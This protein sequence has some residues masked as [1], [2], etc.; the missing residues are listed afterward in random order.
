MN[1]NSKSSIIKQILSETNDYR[2]L[3]TMIVPNMLFDQWSLINT[4]YFYYNSRFQ[5]GATDDE[6]D[7]KYF[8]NIVKNPCMIY[9]KS[10]AFKPESAKLLTTGGGD[11][12]KTWFMERDLKYWMRDKQF[13]KVMNR[14]FH[15]LPIFG[16]VVIKMVQGVPYFVDLRN[17]LIDKSADSL[18][19]MQFIVEQH[20]MTKGE[21]R[22]KAKILGVPQ[23]KI[24]EVI[25]KYEEGKY[26]HI[27]VYERYGDVEVA[28]KVWK[29]QRTFIAD[30]GVDKFLNNNTGAV[31]ISER[32]VELKSEDY[33]GHPYWEFHGQKI[34]GR[35]LGVGVIETLM[36]PQIA[37]NELMNLQSKAAYWAALR[38]FQTR[39]SAV[40]RNLNTDVSNGQIMNVD[41]EI[42]QIDMSDRNL[43][44]FNEMTQKWNANIN[45]LTV[46]FVPIGHSQAAIQVALDRVVTYFEHIQQQVALQ[47]KEMIYSDLMPQ[48]E[49][50]MTAEHV[51]RLVGKDLDTFVQMVKNTM[52]FQE[53][54]RLAVTQGKI[55]TQQDA[56]L[57]G[58]AIEL[59]IKGKKEHLLTVTKGFYK[60]VKYD[61]EIDIAGE[62]ID[63]KGRQQMKMAVLQALT[64][65][66]T[67]TQD[68]AK[69][70]ILSSYMEDGGMNP[71]DIFSVSGNT[72][73][74]PTQSNGGG[75]SGAGGGVSSMN[76]MG[77]APAKTI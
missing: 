5:S 31:Q 27:T 48:F 67:L 50:D 16:S 57:I 63:T 36:E 28:P 13:G 55:C 25:A 24:D 22:K 23:A 76:G 10:I 19:E 60:G 3:P 14:I 56:D 39:D 26:N 77:V 69:K 74:A 29:R 1:P 20:N 38:I 32:G 47:V 64:V 71:N 73:T 58:T 37:H 30:V 42:T 11:S 70:A 44:F 53:I 59:Q 61:L 46:A 12:L 40:N 43:A 33:E 65:D 62:S 7:K 75:F 15:E 21:F 35:W 2:Y 45:D 51:I 54:L 34:P 8:Y 52:V 49:K 17:F 4:I 68:P 72:P 9:E 18:D 66:P 41:S 6:G